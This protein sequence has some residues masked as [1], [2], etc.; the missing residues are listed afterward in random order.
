M[1]WTR[2]P[3]PLLPHLEFLHDI[4]HR[5]YFHITINGY[6][7]ILESHNPPVRAAVETFRKVATKISP[8]LTHWRYDPILL[9][10]ETP[11]E[12]HLEQ[13]DLLA[14]QLGGYTQR[15]YFSFVDFYSKTERNLR[16][17][18][19]EHHITIQHP[20]LETQREL[21]QQLQQIAAAHGITMYSCCNE[22]LVGAGIQ[23][24][25]CIDI[26]TVAKLRPDLDFRLKDAPTRQ[27]CGCVECDDIGSYDT[28][29]FGCTYCYATNSR[30]A[31][32]NRMRDHDPNDTVLWRPSTL[33]GANLVERERSRSKKNVSSKKRPNLQLDLFSRSRIPEKLEN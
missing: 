29:G 24:S 2:N 19:R 22:G 5:Y 32:I 12:Y 20:H 6:P 21:A 17:V 4:G 7:R 31:A 8:D 14:S 27:D 10:E 16:R 30:K 9:S 11:P 1:F 18:E 26:D 15:C 33:R 13:F 23:P 3:K 25:H 28:C